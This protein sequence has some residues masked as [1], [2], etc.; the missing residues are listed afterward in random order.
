MQAYPTKQKKSSVSLVLPLNFLVAYFVVGMLVQ[1]CF[2]RNKYNFKLN[3]SGNLEYTKLPPIP[4]GFHVVFVCTNS[5]PWQQCALLTKI[6]GFEPF[7]FNITLQ[8]EKKKYK[9]FLAIFHWLV[10]YLLTFFAVFES[11]S[12]KDYKSRFIWFWP[13][14]YGPIYEYES[15]QFI[16]DKQFGAQFSKN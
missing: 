11:S 15:V 7:S 13:I 10:K 3:S 16:S 4:L 14:S 12:Q 2:V 6:D 1:L 5:L 8:K 9:L